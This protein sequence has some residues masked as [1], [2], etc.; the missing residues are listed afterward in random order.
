MQDHFEEGVCFRYGLLRGAGNTA[1]YLTS[2]ADLVYEPGENLELDLNEN[3]DSRRSLHEDHA[4]ATAN[5][6]GATSYSVASVHN[7]SSIG[8]SHA[9]HA[10]K[11]SRTVPEE[12]SVIVIR[13]VYSDAE[14]DYCDEECATEG[15]WGEVSGG[16]GSVMGSVAG[17]M[18]ESSYGKSSWPREKGRVI[19][20]NMGRSVNDADSGCPVFAESIIADELAVE[21]TPRATRTAN[22][23]RTA[24]APTPAAPHRARPCHRPPRAAHPQ[25]SASTR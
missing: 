8:R 25:S 18:L 12:R 6:M 3:H 20:V 9:R 11:T 14:P 22:R 1:Y 5:Y 7:R 15:M 21:R 19:S 13:M 23:A 10:A 4:G 24:P 2:P 16:W 17:V